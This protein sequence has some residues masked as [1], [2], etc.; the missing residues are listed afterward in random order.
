MKPKIFI[1]SISVLICALTFV[2]CKKEKTDDP[3]TSIAGII[4][5]AVSH[6]GITAN[7][8]LNPGNITQTTEADGKY[9]F[10]IIDTT[11]TYSIAITA[12]N[13]RDETINYIGVRFGKRTTV[14]IPLTKLNPQLTYTVPYSGVSW[15]IETQQ[16]ISWTS[17]DLTGNIKI[18][19]IKGSAVNQ[20]IVASTANSGTYTWALPNN[21]VAGTDYKIRISS[22]TNTSISFESN[23]FSIS[24]LP[25]P[26]AT[27]QSATNLGST[28]A[29]LNGLVN[30]NGQ[31]TNSDI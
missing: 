28:T 25:L 22:V 24:T 15:H 20:T 4:T 11:K 13:Y 6:N 10:E 27:T 26:S 31:S 18:E 17:S 16:T 9:Q 2:T 21:L 8:T 1:L 3:F 19:L 29:T 5:D 30:A 14:D 23:S 7:V 12:P